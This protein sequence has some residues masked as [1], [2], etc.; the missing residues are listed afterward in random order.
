MQECP[1]ITYTLLLGKNLSSLLPTFAYPDFDI[2]EEL[3]AGTMGSVAS[4]T[5]DEKMVVVKNINAVKS[6]SHVGKKILKE[7]EI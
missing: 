3:R 5:Y 1:P 2:S 6:Y 7:A 4:G